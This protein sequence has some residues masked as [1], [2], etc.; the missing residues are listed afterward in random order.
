MAEPLRVLI[1]EDSEDDTSLLVRELQRAGY[2]VSW[3]RVDTAGAMRSALEGR[4]WDLI[5][6]DYNMPSFSA[7]AALALL[8]KLD[9][10]LPFIIVSGSVGED[11][12]VEVMRAGAHDYLSKGNLKRLF[13]AIQRELGQAGQRRARRHADEQYRELVANAPIGIFQMAPDGT[14]VSANAVLGYKLGYDSAE[15]LLIR[16]PP[17]DVFF[18]P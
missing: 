10:D 4:S 12:A 13:P 1:V 5:V 16:D 18:E 11:I 8:Q 6:A 3:E 7:P 14:F 15:E 9:I 2:D 17:R